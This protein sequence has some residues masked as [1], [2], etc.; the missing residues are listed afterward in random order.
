MK[1]KPARAKPGQGQCVSGSKQ[2]DAYSA[3]KE[4]SKLVINKPF[5]YSNYGKI[6]TKKHTLEKD[7]DEERI[8][9]LL[10]CKSK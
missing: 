8:E 6:S 5:V 7:W 4:F 1:D 9:V 10:S 2:D 3:S